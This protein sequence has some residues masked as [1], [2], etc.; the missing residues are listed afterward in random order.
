MSGG[1]FAGIFT[2]FE[3][4]DW[5]DDPVDGYRILCPLYD[6]FHRLID[7]RAFVQ[8]VPCDRRGIDAFHRFL[9]LTERERVECLPAP[10]PACAVR[11]AAVPLFVSESGAEKAPVA[12]VHRNQQPFPGLC[13]NRAFPQDHRF[14]IDVVVDGCSRA[15]Q[16]KE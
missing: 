8:C 7:H 12:H 16:R 6:L 4:V 13:G 1:S 5:F 14:R 11:R 15:F 10:H 2:S 9:E 3:I